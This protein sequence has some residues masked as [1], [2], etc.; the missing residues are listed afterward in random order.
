[1]SGLDLIPEV[2]PHRPDLPVFMISAYGDAD[3]EAMALARGADG[4]LTKPEDFLKLKQNIMAVI[5]DAMGEKR[6]TRPI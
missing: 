1:M 2:K 6:M 3:T 4:F 5:T